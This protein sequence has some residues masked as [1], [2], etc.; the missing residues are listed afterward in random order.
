MWWGPEPEPAAEHLPL[1][2]LGVELMEME[3]GAEQAQEDGA[4]VEDDAVAE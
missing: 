3:D 1:L 4:M 2:A